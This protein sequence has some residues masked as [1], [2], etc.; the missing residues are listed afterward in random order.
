MHS[1][2]RVRTAVV[3]RWRA[4][5]EAQRSHPLH[6]HL[7]LWCTFACAWKTRRLRSGRR[8]SRHS[9]PPRRPCRPHCAL[10]RQPRGGL[11]SG[12]AHGSLFL[13]FWGAPTSHKL[14]RSTRAHGLSRLRRAAAS[15]CPSSLTGCCTQQ[16]AA[17]TDRWTWIHA[18]GA[19][20]TV[21]RKGTYC[22]GTHCDGKPLTNST[23]PPPFLARRV[24]EHAPAIR[25]NACCGRL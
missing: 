18:T 15:A 14:R 9:L 5:R 16:Q 23:H 6:P 8:A 11:P 24:A 21:C 20:T 4:T 12:V 17:A 1:A 19:Q 2:V 3:C 10:L 7:P 25:R 13:A 22:K